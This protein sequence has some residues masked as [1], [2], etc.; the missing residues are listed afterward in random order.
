MKKQESMDTN[1]NKQDF[2]EL[3]EKYLDGKISLEE[4]KLLVNYY[5]SFKLENDWVDELGAE[6]PIKHRML[7]NI[8]EAIQD[9]EPQ[10]S[11]IISLL[12]S[13]IFKYGAA[14]AIL[15][16]VFF[17]AVYN[18]NSLQVQ[19]PA[20]ISVEN[21]TI[22]I[23]SNK[24]TLTTEDGTE[25]ILEKGKSYSSK[26]LSSNGE[27][28]LYNENEK[29]AKAIVYNYLT[30]PRGGEFF[31]KLADGTQVWLNSESKLKFPVSFIEG[32]TRKVELVYGE[33][34]FE[35]TP[36]EAHR[37]AK[38]Q[39]ITGIQEIEVIG[40][41]FN[42]Q[43]YK[44]DKIIKTSLVEGK[45]NVKNNSIEKNLKPGQ[46]SYLSVDSGKITVSDVDIENTIAWKKGYFMFN[47]ES[48]E[49]MTN[50]LSRWY[51]VVFIFE[52]E[53]KKHI[54]FTGVLKRS[55]NIQKLL[56]KLEKTNEAFFQI[57]NNQ[58][59]IK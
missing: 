50:I 47:N 25:I 52:N 1:Y 5:H 8:L 38:F 31:V 57:Q 6:E 37:G 51:N 7:I 42:V 22:Q 19:K 35:V 26:N 21:N 20:Q 48:L 2:Q 41:Q 16:F 14:A 43:A 27:K 32:E 12:K 11:K 29:Y 49:S 10:E 4:V 17:N 36:S 3:I 18:S 40:T 44:D 54:R 53:K 28:L 9:E 23:G 15:L 58:I 56:N 13:N 45:V 39:V 33:A 55:D 24:A 46:A 34:Y 30:I 59:T